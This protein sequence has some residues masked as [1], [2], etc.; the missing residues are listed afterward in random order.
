[1]V[2]R[3]ALA[4]VEHNPLSSEEG[5]PEASIP[6]YTDDEASDEEV[7]QARCMSD[8]GSMGRAPGNES[9]ACWATRQD[10]FPGALFGIQIVP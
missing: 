9:T 7:D 6:G 8:D 3:G 4:T 1:M 2:T 10:D 5:N